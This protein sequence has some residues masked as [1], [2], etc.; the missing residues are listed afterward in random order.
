MKTLMPRRF[1]PI[2]VVTSFCLFLG[3]ASARADETTTN[4]LSVQW[5]PGATIPQ[6]SVGAPEDAVTVLLGSPTLQA[7][8]EVLRGHGPIP[9]VPEA[10]AA[11]RS[12][13]FY[14]ARYQE[15]TD[16]DDWKN[17][18]RAQLDP[19]Q[20]PEPSPDQPESRWVKFVILLSS[21]HR[22]I[23]Q[24]STKYPFHYDFAV[25]RI[26]EFQNLTRAQFDAVT[27]HTNAQQAVLGAVLFPPTTNLVEAGL[28]F[29]GFDAYPREAVAGWFQTV[30]PML[31]LSV[32]R[33]GGPSPTS[34][35]RRVGRWA[36]WSTFRPMRSA[37]PIATA[38][39]DRTIFC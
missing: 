23:F 36:G 17:V 16:L 22:V 15:K 20:S 21:P 33:R 26:P 11:G 2:I 13:G 10:S 34:S 5:P 18:I 8:T 35:M 24:D 27:L 39:C 38:A 4:R 6:V 32:R 19:F 28:Q 30:R 3:L 1:L 12:Q 14:R 31:G 9:F 25:K 7:W 29:V 37:M